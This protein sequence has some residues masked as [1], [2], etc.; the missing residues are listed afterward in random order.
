MFRKIVEC[1]TKKFFQIHACMI[2]VRK[3][4]HLDATTMFTY[5]HANIP[6]GQSERAYYLSNFIKCNIILNGLSLEESFH[7]SKWECC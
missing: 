1:S 6:L 4:K 3:A 2:I 5:S 7:I